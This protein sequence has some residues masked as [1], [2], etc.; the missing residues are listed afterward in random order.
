MGLKGEELP[1]LYRAYMSISMTIGASITC[2]FPH[3]SQEA[4]KQHLGLLPILGSAEE[5]IWP[6]VVAELFFVS[7][8]CHTPRPQV[9][10]PV[11]RDFMY[12]TLP[13]S[14]TLTLVW[15]CHQV[16]PCA[17]SRTSDFLS[18]YHIPKTWLRMA[19]TSCGGMTKPVWTLPI[20]TFH[21]P[22]HNTTMTWFIPKCFR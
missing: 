1:F 5:E 15:L 14:S 10:V 22:Y 20:K 19:H 17:T 13:S 2:S 18:C 3:P 16:D 4:K 12:L 6:V 7:Q 8:I 9:S 11:C 21:Y